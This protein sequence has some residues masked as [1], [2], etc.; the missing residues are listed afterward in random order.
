MVEKSLLRK[1]GLTDNEAEVY[2]ILL[3]LEEALA[4][5][6]ASHTRVS[7]PHVYD[8]L[9]KLI[10]KG[11]ASYVIKN[12]R[13]Y[14]R[15]ASPHKLLD[16]LKDKEALLKRE[17]KEVTAALPA[18]LTMHKPREAKPV[19]EVFEG[20]EG[21]K[22]ILDDIIKTCKDDPKAARFVGFGESAKRGEAIAPYAFK[23]YM[24]QR[25]KH[26]IPARF[27]YREGIE[28]LGAPFSEY[29][30]IPKEYSSKSMT[31]MYGNK[32]A[33]WIWLEKK[34]LII[35]IESRDVA[36]TYRGHFEVMWEQE[37]RVLHGLDGAREV[38][39][40]ILRTNKEPFFMTVSGSYDQRLPKELK[41]YL[42]ELNRRGM[43]EYII[44]PNK[45]L[46]TYHE[47]SMMKFVPKEYFS[48]VQTIV[49]GNRVAIV[50]WKGPIT[51]LMM[52]N[53]AMADSFRKYFRMIWD[54]EAMVYKGIEG[55]SMAFDTMLRDAKRGDCMYVAAVAPPTKRINK[56]FVD[57]NNRRVKRGIHSKKIFTQEGRKFGEERAKLPITEVRYAPKGFVSM[58]AINMF[59]D[60]VAIVL[61]SKKVPM[62]LLIENEEIAKSLKSYFDFL[63]ERKTGTYEGVEEV[64]GFLHGML[65]EVGKGGR[66]YATGSRWGSYMKPYMTKE[67]RRFHA[68]RIRKG[69]KA[70]IIFDSG[71]RDYCRKMK[72]NWKLA[73]VSFMP[74]KG[75]SLRSPVSTFIF[76]DKTFMIVWKKEPTG[77]LI[78]DREVVMHYRDYYDAMRAVSKP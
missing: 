7:R 49:Y 44:V 23:K 10:D 36:E 57:F 1:I 56:F 62:V 28:T 24:A 8:S 67:F 35:R 27:L 6:I 15:G 17:E 39:K 42:D 72:G 2:L 64:F 73:D 70:N 66:Y 74:R 60:R 4:S 61:P 65:D 12:N 58:A 29:R 22:T 16:Y 20:K 53:E 19:V 30:P 31:I 34:P 32:T 40:D 14:F 75:S 71:A 25:K 77:F 55:I 52:E 41:E 59:K 47:A 69:V 63:W 54:Q 78:E 37:T 38:L 33:V 26:K 13:K 5:E 51:V 43:K 9:N 3:K 76:K 18:L 68:A 21:M 46:V 48:P 50:N 11:L 45:D